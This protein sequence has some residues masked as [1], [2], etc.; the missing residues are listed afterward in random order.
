MLRLVLL[1]LYLVASSF[2]SPQARQDGLW[3]SPRPGSSLHAL[4]AHAGSGYD[5]NGTSS[6]RPPVDPTSDAGAGFDPNG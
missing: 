1:V 4:T 6:S 2:A 3:T 5:P